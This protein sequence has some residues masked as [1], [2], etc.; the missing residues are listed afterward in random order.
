MEKQDAFSAGELK[1]LP[2][3]PSTALCGVQFEASG[4]TGFVM[5]SLML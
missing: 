4:S 1:L 2:V 3:G 5:P